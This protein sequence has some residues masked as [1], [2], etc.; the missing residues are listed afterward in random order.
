MNRFKTL[1]RRLV[2]PGESCWYSSR[3][4]IYNEYGA[5]AYVHANDEQEAIDLA[6]DSGHLDCQLMAESDYADYQA[7]GWDDSYITAGNAGEPFW[8]VY[9]GISDIT[10]R[11]KS[12]ANS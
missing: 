3:F 6:A 8:S 4:V 7:K 10:E 11:S 1:K 12:N 5:I 2:N 9:L